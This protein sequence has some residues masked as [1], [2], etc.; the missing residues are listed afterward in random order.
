YYGGGVSWGATS[1][2]SGSTASSY[3]SWSGNGLQ[4]ELTAGY[5]MP[6]ATELRVFFQADATLPFY[7]THGQ[8][9]TY[10]QS[11][12]TTVTTGSRYNPSITLSVGIGWQHH[13]H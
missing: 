11:H 5:E 4:G 13:R 6:R 8:T 2:N 10:T 12:T 1:G 3:S 7:Y 9:V